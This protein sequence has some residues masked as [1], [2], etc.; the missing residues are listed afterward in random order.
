[1]DDINDTESFLADY[2]PRAYD[3][4]GPR[5]GPRAKLYRHG[6]ATLLHPALLRP[7]SEEAARP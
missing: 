3:P 4:G 6:D 2:D 5:G 1:V 7:A